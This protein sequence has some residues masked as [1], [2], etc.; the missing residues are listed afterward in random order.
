MNRLCLLAFLLMLTSCTTDLSYRYYGANP[1][2]LPKQPNEV[3]ILYERPSKEYEAIADF[4]GRGASSL[5]DTFQ[6]AAAKIGADAVIV[7][8]TDEAYDQSTTWA[9]TGV[10]TAKKR[11]SFLN[12]R[13][14]GTAIIYKKTGT[15][16]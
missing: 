13:I 7:T 5:V 15:E 10:G 4:Q 2:A 14:F 1:V 6:E 9:G 3:E 16:K 11:E 8:N 12:K